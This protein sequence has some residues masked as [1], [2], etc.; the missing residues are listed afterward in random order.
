MLKVYARQAN[1][2]ETNFGR[3]ICWTK[4][5]GLSLVII[6]SIKSRLIEDGQVRETISELLLT[7]S[8]IENEMKHHVN[9][10]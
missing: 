7:L 5:F 3:D 4:N 6:S 9:R 10:N 8:T 2:P 1:G